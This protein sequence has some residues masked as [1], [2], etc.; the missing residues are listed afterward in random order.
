MS[1]KIHY[2]EAVSPTISKELKE[3]LNLRKY[4]IR[5]YLFLAYSNS[6]TVLYI[7]N[8]KYMTINI[9]NNSILL[10]SFSSF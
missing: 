1:L 6:N 4:H 5:Q 2:Q 8:W 3:I 7:F 9:S 10:P